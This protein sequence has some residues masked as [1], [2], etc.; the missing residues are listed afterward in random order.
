MF[1]QNPEKVEKNPLRQA[2]K[3]KGYG[4]RS[5]ARALDVHP[6]VLSIMISGHDEDKRLAE[7]IDALPPVIKKPAQMSTSKK[8]K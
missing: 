6:T 7:K 8:T 1:T 2:L 5:A 3:K 4:V